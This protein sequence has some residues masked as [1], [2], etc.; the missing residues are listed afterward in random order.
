MPLDAPNTI[1]YVVGA[2]VLSPWTPSGWPWV[3]L[4][5]SG[6]LWAPLGGSGRLWAPL[7]ACG[8]LWVPPGPFQ[9]QSDNDH[10]KGIVFYCSCY[11]QTGRTGAGAC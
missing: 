11:E 3:A 8:R 1:K 7:G 6:R 4:G 2:L 10:V 5:G 9:I